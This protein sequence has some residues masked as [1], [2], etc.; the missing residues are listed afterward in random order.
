MVGETLLAVVFGVLLGLPAALLVARSLS[1]QLF[2]VEPFDPVAFAAAL[3]LL[4]AA[5]AFGTLPPLRRAQNVDPAR[6][7]RTD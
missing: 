2:G 1:P 7:L 3:L 4:T 5:T 6:V